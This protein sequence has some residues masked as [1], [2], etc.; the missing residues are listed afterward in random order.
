MFRTLKLIKP[1]TLT[2]FKYDTE[3]IV[4]AFQASVRVVVTEES[5]DDWPSFP[6]ANADR[7]KGDKQISNHLTYL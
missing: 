5:L 4:K 6:V 7:S 2:V 1:F 3:G